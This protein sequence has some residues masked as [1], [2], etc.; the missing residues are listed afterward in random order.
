MIKEAYEKIELGKTK[1]KVGDPVAVPSAQ[2]SGVIQEVIGDEGVAMY[3]VQ[4]GKGNL[5]GYYLESD[6]K[7]TAVDKTAGP[8]VQNTSLPDV[9]PE[10]GPKDENEE[11]Y[12]RMPKPEQTPSGKDKGRPGADDKVQPKAKPIDTSKVSP[13]DQHRI[14][15]EQ[16]DKEQIEQFE[17]QF[18]HGSKEHKPTGE[19][20]KIEQPKEKAKPSPKDKFKPLTPETNPGMFKRINKPVEDNN[21]KKWFDEKTKGKE[22]PSKEKKQ[23]SWQTG[24]KGGKFTVGPGGKKQYAAITDRNGVTIEVG[25]HIVDVAFQQGGEGIVTKV[26]QSE[27]DG[28]GIVVYKN[29]ILGGKEDIAYAKDCAVSKRASVKLTPDGKCDCSCHDSGRGYEIQC[30]QCIADKA[31]CTACMAGITYSAS[32]KIAKRFLEGD[33]VRSKTNPEWGIGIVNEDQF[34]DDIDIKWNRGN[35]TSATFN[36]NEHKIVKAAARCQ[37]CGAI[38]KDGEEILCMD[39]VSSE[40]S[41]LNKTGSM[42]TCDCCD[43]TNVECKSIEGHP[44]CTECYPAMERNHNADNLLKT[45]YDNIENK[46]VVVEFEYGDQVKI[47]EEANVPV[48]EKGHIGMIV[49]QTPSQDGRLTVKF[50]DGHTDTFKAEDLEQLTKT[51]DSFQ[52]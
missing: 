13:K 32:K 15:Q 17:Q 31:P 4:D 2:I 38:L 29:D 10:F 20:P 14:E 19:A 45:A 35:D 16:K 33:E 51:N 28:Q 8:A 47:K 41:L 43:R 25:D 49:N 9:P 1:Y 23:R 5:F 12:A 30:D 18:P 48:M 40:P 42:G 24:P 46:K 52:E 50:Y 11:Y 37:D 36:I 3:R 44:Y 21:N 22:K 26:R 39:C 7:K 6:L 27:V 34:N